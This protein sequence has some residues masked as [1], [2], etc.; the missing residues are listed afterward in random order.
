VSE[1]TSLPLV[2]LRDRLQS[3]SLSSAEIVAAYRDSYLADSRSERPLNGYIEW[4]DDALALAEAADAERR[5]G[6]DA[7]GRNSAE[8][9]GVGDTS[10][11]GGKPLLGLPIAVK[12]NI[13]IKGQAGHLRLRD[14]EGLYGSLFGH[15]H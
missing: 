11:R 1:I 10:G 12:D 15:G 3:G 14:P 9:R 13:L 4:F 6:T 2:E 7:D 5:N 8:R